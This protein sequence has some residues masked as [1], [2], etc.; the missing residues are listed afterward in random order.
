MCEH[1]W[2][3]RLGCFDDYDWRR[4]EL[5][6]AITAACLSPLFF[7]LA[8]D[9]QAKR[10]ANLVER[11][12]LAPGGLLT[13]LE[14]SGLQWD[15]PNGWA[16]LQW[17]AVQGLKHYG[18]VDLARE[19]RTRWLDS[20]KRVFAESGRLVEKYDVVERIAGG[21]GEYPVQEGFGWTNGVTKA[22]LDA[23]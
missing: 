5:R 11:S 20:V 7:K 16:P 13:S 19:V 18:A 1:L 22:F 17:L 9:D 3:Q 14:R 2:D 21:G 23:E 12:L 10:T 6:N 4:G 15:A 8:T